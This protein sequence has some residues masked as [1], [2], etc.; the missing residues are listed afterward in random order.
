[1]GQISVKVLVDRKS[2]CNYDMLEYLRA[3]AAKIR[4]RKFELAN[5][6]KLI[7]E[8]L[9]MK[10]HGILMMLL[11]VLNTLQIMQKL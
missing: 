1:M 10:R 6:R 11:F 7:V 2:D 4:E 3:F 5:S 9:W 8:N